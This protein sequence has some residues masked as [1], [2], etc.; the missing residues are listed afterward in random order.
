MAARWQGAAVAVAG[1]LLVAAAAPL[2]AP[3]DP[4]EQVDPPVSLYRPPG[5]RLAAVH[6]T[7]GWILAERAERT[8]NGLR[9]ARLGRETEL[10]AGE[11]RNLAPTGVADHRFFLLGTD[12]YGR[13]LLSRMLYGARISLAVALSAALLSLT[14]GVAI[15]SAAALGGS[16]LDTILMRLLDATLA[17]PYLFLVIALVALFR[18]GTVAVGALLGATSWMQ[19][20]RLVRAEILGLKDRDFVLAA[21][22]SGQHPLATLFRHL[23]P[24]ALTPV[25]IRGTLL[26]GNLILTE[27][28]LSFLGFG[29]QPPLASWGGIVAEGSNALSDA[30][31]I[32]T[33]P[34]AALA[35]TVILFN[36]LGEGIRD[37]LD[38]RLRD[39]EPRRRPA[40]TLSLDDAE[41]GA[42]LPPL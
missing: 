17:F 20:A 33:F 35:L 38:P 1:L 41:G 27:S 40:A 19:I 6:R 14:V 25:L 28:A 37:A 2:L 24:N 39:R 3:Y 9:I 8:P 23:L 12:R 18:P 30:W 31:W 21:R 34:G 22:A 5:T 10:P 4:D 16:I 36:L 32:A 42:T 29:I 26:I 7:N 11:V 13:D 15:G